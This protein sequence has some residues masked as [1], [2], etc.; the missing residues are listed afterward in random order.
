MSKSAKKAARPK[1][2]REFWLSRRGNGGNIGRFYDSR[3]RFLHRSVAFV[4]E[5][6]TGDDGKERL[7]TRVDELLTQG[8]RDVGRNKAKREARKQLV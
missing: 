6:V 2:D 1:L 4:Q 3:S 8:T 5:M 7:L